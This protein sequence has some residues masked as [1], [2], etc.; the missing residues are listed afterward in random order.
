MTDGLG[1]VPRLKAVGRASAFSFKN[2]PT[3]IP[4]I[5]RQLG[6]T[7]LVAGTV[8][9]E[10]QTVRITAKPITAD[11]FDVWGPTHST[12]SWGPASPWTTT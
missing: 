5:A 1:R 6:V 10:G 8:V 9:Q 4:E 7:H 12:A 3:S 11:G 2:K